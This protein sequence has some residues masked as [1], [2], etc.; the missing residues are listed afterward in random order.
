[1]NRWPVVVIPLGLCLVLADVTVKQ[2]VADRAFSHAKRRLLHYEKQLALYSSGKAPPPEPLTEMEP[3]FA[4]AVRLEPRCA[5]YRNYFGRHYQNLT[6]DPTLTSDRRLQ[7]A[8]KALR[9]YEKAVKC[10]PLNGEYLAWL[11]YLQGALGERNKAIAN[12]EKAVRL[13]RSNEWIQDVYAA[14]RKR[15]EAGENEAVPTLREER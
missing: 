8:R 4:K 15:S 2:Y 10:D 14:F 12:F 3:L 6:A 5:E 13:D 11:A 7:L 1:M 9:E